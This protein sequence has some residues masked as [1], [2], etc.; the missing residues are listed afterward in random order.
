MASSRWIWVSWLHLELY[1]TIGAS[2]PSRKCWTSYYLYLGESASL[3]LST[4]VK[5]TW[6]CISVSREACSTFKWP[7]SSRNFVRLNYCCRNFNWKE[8]GASH[9]ENF[10]H[11]WIFKKIECNWTVG[12]LNVPSEDISVFKTLTLWYWD[13][14]IH[15]NHTPRVLPIYKS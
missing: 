12:E 1:S 8:L 5:S 3:Y 6:N 7:Q 14:K 10:I 13:L 11:F 9:V 4:E 2:V 15:W